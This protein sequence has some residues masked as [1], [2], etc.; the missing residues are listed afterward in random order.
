[1]LHCQSQLVNLLQIINISYDRTKKEEE[2]KIIQTIIYGNVN[3]AILREAKEKSL[4]FLIEK[5]TLK[6]STFTS[7]ASSLFIKEQIYRH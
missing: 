4:P 3:A 2:K 7:C 6:N 1:M 5:G